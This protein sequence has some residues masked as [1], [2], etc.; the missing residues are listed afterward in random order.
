MFCKQQI[1]KITIMIKKLIIP[2]NI[3]CIEELLKY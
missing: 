3:K 2:L 1:R